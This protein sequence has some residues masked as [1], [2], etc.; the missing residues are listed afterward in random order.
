MVDVRALVR[1]ALQLDQGGAVDVAEHHVEHAVGRVGGRDDPDAAAVAGA[2]ADRE[3]HRVDALLLA[4]QAQHVP[5]GLEPDHLD[6]DGQVVPA[7]PAR[8]AHPVGALVDDGVEPGGEHRAVPH[9][10]AVGAGEARE[11]DRPRAAG[12][13][14]VGDGR[15][16][17]ERLGRHA[18]L[19]REVVAGAGGHR[20]ERHVRAGHRLQRQVH[21]AVAAHGHQG[22]GAAGDGRVARR[23]GFFPGTGVEQPDGTLRLGEPVQQGRE[24]ILVPPAPGLRVGEHDQ[25]AGHQ[26]VSS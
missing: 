24:E 26:V 8:P 19:D 14:R 20:A 12:L 22:P 18:G 13:H 7:R 3:Q 2:V 1:L 23:L 11:V 15:R 4:V 9:L 21:G 16:R 5:P 17:R 6:E 10:A 25:V